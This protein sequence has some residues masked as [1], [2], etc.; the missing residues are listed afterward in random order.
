MSA[1][2]TL[3]G[4]TVIGCAKHQDQGGDAADWTG[5][6]FDFFPAMQTCL[7]RAQVEGASATSVA[8]QADGTVLVVVRDVDGS[9][10]NCKTSAAGAALSSF[11]AAPADDPAGAVAPAF[12][13]AASAFSRLGCD[14]PPT[15]VVSNGGELLGYLQRGHCSNGGA[16]PLPAA[17]SGPT[18]N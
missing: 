16:A 12:A 18:P 1:Q 13:R 9:R 14:D 10:F 5:S 4:R 8:A 6:L 17:E 2:A 11:E 15:E 7:S 3:D